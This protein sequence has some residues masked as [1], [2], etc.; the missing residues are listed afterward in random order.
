MSA[1][2]IIIL[3]CPIWVFVDFISYASTGKT[4][5][6]VPIFSIIE[7]LS[8]G[9]MPFIFLSEFDYNLTNDCCSD[10]AV[11]S[12]EHRLTIYAIIVLS[13]VAYFVCV[14]KRTILPPIAEVILNILLII[15]LLLNCFLLFHLD[16]FLGI[17]GNIPII[18]LLLIRLSKNQELF[19]KKLDNYEFNKNSFLNQQSIK[20][21]TLN[22]IIKYPVLL[23]LCAPVLIILTLILLLF[24]QRPDS[25]IRAFTETYKLVIHNLTICAKMCNAG[26]IF[27]VLWVPTDIGIL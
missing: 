20:I 11:F 9:I 19:I 13:G 16:I 6:P 2:I 4:L 18:M 27:F 10:S 17:I 26:N 12:P 24:G 1:L 7:I 14:I 23:L 5:S 3:C 25:A 15:G 22:P 8:I 21:L